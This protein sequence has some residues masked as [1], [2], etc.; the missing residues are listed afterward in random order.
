MMRH[1]NARTNSCLHWMSHDTGA[2]TGITVGKRQKDHP[3]MAGAGAYVATNRHAGGTQRRRSACW[4]IIFG[5]PAENFPDAN[6][7]N[8]Q[9]YAKAMWWCIRLR[10]ADCSMRSAFR[11]I[12]LALLTRELVLTVENSVLDNVDLLDI[13]VA[14]DGHPHH[15]MAGGVGWMWPIT[16]S[17]YSRCSGD[18]QCS[19]I[20]LAN[21]RRRPYLLGGLTPRSTA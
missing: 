17:R 10:K 11:L 19:G 21:I 12:T 18:L 4:S 8:R 15:V 2:R 7:A 6:G 20:S 9:R 1:G 5:L 13:P 14:P 3:A 16:V